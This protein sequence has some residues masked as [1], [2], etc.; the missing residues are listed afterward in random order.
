MRWYVISPSCAIL[1]SKQIHYNGDDD[2]ALCDEG[3]ALLD[4][5]WLNVWNGCRVG[6]CR[7]DR[8]F[9]LLRVCLNLKV[10]ITDVRCSMR[11]YIRN[12]TLVCYFAVQ[13]NT[14]Q[15]RWWLCVVRCVTW[16]SLVE[17]M[18]RMLCW[19]LA[20]R[21]YV[22][23]PACL[24]EAESVNY[25]RSIQY[26]VVCNLT[27]PRALFCCPNKYTTMAMMTVRFAMTGLRYLTFV[28]WMYGT[29]V[30]LALG[31]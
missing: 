24:L 5:R 4:L 13:T 15:W 16:P 3:S 8:T 2:C 12:L 11:S 7:T 17:C 23:T 26:E 19:P 29:D 18:E 22:F 9:V 30:V 31:A 28:G 6:P 25:W 21:A 14:L 1:L 20:N 10:L 27:Y